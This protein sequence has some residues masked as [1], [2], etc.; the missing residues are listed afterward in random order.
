MPT[1]VRISEDEVMIGG[2]VYKL[3]EEYHPGIRRILTA[4][5]KPVKTSLPA[6]PPGALTGKLIQIVIEEETQDRRDVLFPPAKVVKHAFNTDKRPVFL[7]KFTELIADSNEGEYA[8]HPSSLRQIVFQ[9][10]VPGWEPQLMVHVGES[11]EGIMAELLVPTVFLGVLPDR[12]ITSRELGSY[13]DLEHMVRVEPQLLKQHGLVDL[14]FG[15]FQVFEDGVGFR[16]EWPETR[17]K[18]ALKLREQQL[19]KKTGQC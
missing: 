2:R 8:G 13:P 19:M 16:H 7:A 15:V 14:G 4:N 12:L 1:G 3:G 9:S 6:I 11:S 10:V 17:W 18:D 5:G